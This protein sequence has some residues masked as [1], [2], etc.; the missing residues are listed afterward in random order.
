[1]DQLP[2]KYAIMFQFEAFYEDL[3]IAGIKWN[4]TKTDD[5]KIKK[6]S[7]ENYEKLGRNREN[8]R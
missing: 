5:D 3:K 4:R 2:Q 8:I 6:E 7:N 1:M